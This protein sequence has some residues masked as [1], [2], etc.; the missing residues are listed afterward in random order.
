MREEALERGR[1]LQHLAGLEGEQM[2]T[3]TDV[4]KFERVAQHKIVVYYRGL[5]E[6]ALH[7][8]DSDYHRCENP[9]LILL[10]Q[11]HYYGIKNVEG[12]PGMLQ[13]LLQ[14]LPRH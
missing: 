12:L 4:R 1:E 14:E 7:W 2:V 3:L 5:D 11:G 13:I 10:F 6:R 8:L 9:L